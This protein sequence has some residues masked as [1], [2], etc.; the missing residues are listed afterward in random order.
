MG[1]AVGG[2]S[3]SFLS[4]MSDLL[5]DAVII[6]HR[7]LGS[8]DLDTGDATFIEAPLWSGSGLLRPYSRKISDGIAPLIAGVALAIPSFELWTPLLELPDVPKES[9]TVRV[10]GATYPLLKPPQRNVGVGL[11]HHKFFLAEAL[12]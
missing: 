5:N 1:A 7:T 3:V 4:E 8:K 6:T 10:N 2:D 9:I 12:L 11:D